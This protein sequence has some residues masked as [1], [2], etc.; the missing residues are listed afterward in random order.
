[1]SDI[2]GINKPHMWVPKEVSNRMEG[3][4]NMQHYQL[5]SM[6]HVT[7]ADF[8]F[9]PRPGFY[10]MI[11]FFNRTQYNYLQVFL[12]SFDAGKD[13]DEND[14]NKMTLLFGTSDS[15]EIDAPFPLYAVRS[16]G[17]YEQ[18]PDSERWINEYKTRKMPVLNTSLVR[19]P[20][21]NYCHAANSMTN[22]RR[23]SYERNYINELMAEIDNLDSHYAWVSGFRATF[24][25]Y[26]FRGKPNDPICNFINRI[27]VIFEFTKK[28]D[29]KDVVFY[30][31]DVPG[32]MDRPAS[33]NII[34]NRSPFLGVDNGH[35]CPPC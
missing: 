16:N 27:F 33:H 24:S 19:D 22:T 2:T 32:F 12:A 35:L 34:Q 15:L 10:E 21:E 14:K 28:A 31:D 4:F 1:M 3:N 13:V 5:S 7:E 9:L 11:N 25:S 26:C 17:S 6:M 20:V 18:D 29:G 8:V 30:L 23:I